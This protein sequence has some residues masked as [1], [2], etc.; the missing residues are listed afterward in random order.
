MPQNRIPKVI[1]LKKNNLLFEKNGFKFNG[2]FISRNFKKAVKASTINPDI[3]FHDL[4]HS[5]A[6]N[7]VKKGISIFIVKELL[8]HKDVKTTQVYSHLTVES[9][10]DAVKVLES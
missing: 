5:F 4:R 8:R 2:D 1:S 7:M 6:S 10:K 3:H 9:L